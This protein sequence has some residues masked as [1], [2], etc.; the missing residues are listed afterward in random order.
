MCWLTNNRRTHMGDIRGGNTFAYKTSEMTLWQESD[1]AV[2]PFCFIH[3]PATPWEDNIETVSPRW[4]FRRSQDMKSTD[5]GFSGVSSAWTCGARV[6]NMNMHD[7]GNSRFHGLA[8]IEIPQRT[9]SP[10]KRVRLLVCCQAAKEGVKPIS[11]S[12]HNRV[13]LTLIHSVYF[14]PESTTTTTTT[15]TATTTT[16]STFFSGGRRVVLQ[17]N[18]SSSSCCEALASDMWQLKMTEIRFWK[19]RTCHESLQPGDVNVVNVVMASQYVTY[20]D[21]H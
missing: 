21:K 6:E 4:T 17:D 19:D 15:T 20:E 7:D 11:V 18:K 16:M 8:V 13:S 10:R 14:N 5:Y 3:P 9:R 2:D 1:T 12:I